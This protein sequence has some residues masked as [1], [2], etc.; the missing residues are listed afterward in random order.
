VVVEVELM[1][2]LQ[3]QEVLLEQVDQVVEEME[4][5]ILKEKLI[6]LEQLILVVVVEEL[7]ESSGQCFRCSWW[8]R[9]SNNKV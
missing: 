2:D 4:E 8:F 9:Y 3:V 6:L 5:L 7:V 1:L